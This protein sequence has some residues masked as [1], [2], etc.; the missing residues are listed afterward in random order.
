MSSTLVEMYELVVVDYPLTHPTGWTIQWLYLAA[1][2]CK[3]IGSDRIGSEQDVLEIG[4][5][6]MPRKVCLRAAPDA[7]VRGDSPTGK[8]VKQHTKE[9]CSRNLIQQSAHSLIRLE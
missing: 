8:T 5:R 4:A 2:G 6:L 9:H 7:R 1:Y 3:I